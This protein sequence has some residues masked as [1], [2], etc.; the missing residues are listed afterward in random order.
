MLPS[1]ILGKYPTSKSI[2][3]S[4]SAIPDKTAETVARFIY[5]QIFC[6]YLAPGEIIIHDGGPEFCNALV[7]GMIADF[8]VKVS[9]TLPGRPQGNGQAEAVVRNVKNKLRMQNFSEGKQ[10]I[11]RSKE[12]EKFKYF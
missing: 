10:N 3:C 7:Q 5:D 4:F 12:L 9:V 8:N 6:R 2:S 11:Y 1:E